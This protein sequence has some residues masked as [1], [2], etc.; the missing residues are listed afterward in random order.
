[1]TVISVTSGIFNWVF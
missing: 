1:V